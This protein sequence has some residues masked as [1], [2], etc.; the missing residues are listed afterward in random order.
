MTNTEPVTQLE[1][2]NLYNAENVICDILEGLS[3][4]RDEAEQEE[5]I[6]LISNLKDMLN[7]YDSI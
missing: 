7:T 1:V 4:G 6:C 3:C 2:N 5:L